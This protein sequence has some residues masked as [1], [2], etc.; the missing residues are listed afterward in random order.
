MAHLLSAQNR[1]YFTIRLISRIHH[2]LFYR[3]S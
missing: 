1:P 2:L 3:V